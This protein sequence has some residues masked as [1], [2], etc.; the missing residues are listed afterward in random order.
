VGRLSAER[1]ALLRHLED[2]DVVVLS[3]DIHVAMALQ[4]EYPSRP[5]DS[6][7]AE[8]V[9]SSLTSQNLDDKGGWGYRTKSLEA[10]RELMELMPNIRYVDMDS[11]G[12]M[13]VDVTRERV[14]VEWWFVDTVLERTT[15]Q[16]LAPPSRSRRA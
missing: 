14:R 7:A 15:G 4:L 8:F 10:E 1:D 5:G 6:L 12:Y 16:R 11:H 9:T 13:V 2:R 3:G